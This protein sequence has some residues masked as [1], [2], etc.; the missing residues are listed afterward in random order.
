MKTD[1]LK[2]IFKA[3]LI[4]LG[5]RNVKSEVKQKE[6]LSNIRN[7]KQNILDN[8]DKLEKEIDHFCLNELEQLKNPASLDSENIEMR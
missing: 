8:L 3:Y 2:G 7:F 6:K 5:T 4:N 1:L